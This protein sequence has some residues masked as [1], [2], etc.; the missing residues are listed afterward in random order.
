MKFIIA[1]NLVLKVSLFR[2]AIYLTG[3]FIKSLLFSP[4]SMK[5]ILI[6]LP[7]CCYSL[8]NRDS[9]RWFEVYLFS[10]D[11]DLSDVTDQT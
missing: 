4:S 11:V 8:L 6:F 10:Q 2:V 7:K 1:R 9:L 5:H 3:F